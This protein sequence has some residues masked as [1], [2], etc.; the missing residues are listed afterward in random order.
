MK[1]KNR[2]APLLLALAMP[3]AAAAADWPT[4]PVRV[5]VPFPAGGPTDGV[6]RAVLGHM[7]KTLG[8]PLV[9][10]NKPGAEGAIAVQAAVAAPPDGY[11]LLFATSSVMAL[12]AVA[13]PAPFQL[14]DLAPVG[15]VGHF[16][17]GLFVS[18]Q[19]P[20][21]NVAELVA[22][23]RANPGKLNYASANLGE[24]M[25]AAQLLR[26]TGTDMVRIP[27][28]GAAQAIPDLLANRVQVY[29]TPMVAG[30][31]HA[32]EGRLKLLATLQPERAALA[33]EVPSAPEAGIGGVGVQSWQMLLA[34]AKTPRDVLQRAA[35]ALDLAL[36]DP[37]VRSQLQ[38]RSIVVQGMASARLAAMLDEAA[39]EWSGFARENGLV[40]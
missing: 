30:L 11:T 3:V 32:K 28:K 31:Q 38:A 17:F 15:T 16:P 1:T 36:E 8:Q 10:E 35:R 24:Q 18:T 27:Y 12:P 19:V 9:V 4:K 13:R 22:H 25:A 39:R 14:S 26:V 34:P 40:P 7:S 29:L 37:D 20:A 6:A 5:V 23:A 33:P 21:A 2:I